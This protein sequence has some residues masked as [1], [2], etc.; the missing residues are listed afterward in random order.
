MTTPMHSPLFV[1]TDQSI[2]LNDSQYFDYLY[3]SIRDA[4]TSI[5]VGQ[6]IINIRPDSDS[7]RKVIELCDALSE[8]AWRGV[9]TRVLVSKFITPPPSMDNNAITSRYLV[10]RGVQIKSYAPFEGSRRNLFHSKFVIIDSRLTILG[11]HN[12]TA[13]ALNVNHESSIAITST[14]VAIQ[15]ESIFNSLW[16]HA[17]V[18][19]DSL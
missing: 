4:R 15:M 18:A 8:A 6:F 13:N 11:S 3:A 17:E 5:I 2:I 12:W 1:P 9:D 16:V 7:Q 14:D 10:K 19:F